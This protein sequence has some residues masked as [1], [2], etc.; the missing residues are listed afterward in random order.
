MVQDGDHRRRTGPRQPKHNDEGKIFLMPN[1]WAIIGE[2]ASRQTAL[3]TV[4]KSMEKLLLRDY[5][6]VLNFPAFTKPR[7]DVGYVTRY[8][9][10]LRENG[11]VYTHAATWAVTDVRQGRPSPTS[12]TA[13]S[14]AS[15]RPT[16]PHDPDRY[17]AEPYVTCGNSDGPISPYYGRGGWTWYTGSAQWLHRVAVCDILGVKATYDGL[18]IEPHDPSRMARDTRTRRNFRGATYDIAVVRGPQTGD[19]R[20]RHRPCKATSSRI[21]GTARPHQ[22]RVVFK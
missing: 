17:V 20:R 22:V 10:G 15:A 6:T 7:T 21:S 16:A 8:A 9:P 3:K 2:H 11:G 1:A 18:V 19:R 12:P 5:G 14:A 13:P 4:V